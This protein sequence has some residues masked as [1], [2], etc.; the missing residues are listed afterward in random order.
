MD[1]SKSEHFGDD[2]LWFIIQD[3][4]NFPGDSV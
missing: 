3:D 2:F 1:Y 4:L